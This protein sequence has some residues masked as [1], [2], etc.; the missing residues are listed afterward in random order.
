MKHF[1]LS[2]KNSKLTI[3]DQTKLPLKVSYLEIKT[4]KD[5]FTAIK[6]LKVRGAPLIGVFAGYSVYVSIKNIKTKSK[7]AFLKTVF[8]NIQHLKISRPTA[9]N[10][11]W[12]LD[13]IQNKIIAN[14]NRSIKTIK[15]VIK[16]ESRA[17]HNEDIKLCQGIAAFG[18]KLIKPKDAI[19]THCNAGFLATSGQG[20]ALAIIYR[21]HK[22]YPGIKVFADETR[23]LLQGARLTAWEL[24]SRKIDTTLIC[25]NAAAA[26]IKAGQIDKTIVGADRITK[27]GA[28]ANKIGTYSLAVLCKYHKIP[29]YVAAPSSTFD[30]N[31]RSWRSIP[32]EE[33]SPQEIKS[34]FGKAIAPKKVKAYNPAFDITPPQLIT[35]IITEKGIIRPP[36]GKN[37][38]KVIG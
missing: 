23:P 21:A 1:S 22:R 27:D 32:I 26:L 11:F 13:R 25:D 17:I 37:I 24:T 16:N 28:A 14:K 5:A 29:F 33:R 20:T 18:A 3:I 34:V 36:Y 10:L 30:L 6:R 7:K 12:A 38:K 2:F 19:L 9:V 8:N 35:A 15:T 4:I 31:L